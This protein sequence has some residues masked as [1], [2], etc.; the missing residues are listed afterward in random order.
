MH[1]KQNLLQIQNQ[2]AYLNSNNIMQD[3]ISKSIY[4]EDPSYVRNNPSDESFIQ[5]VINQA[6]NS[7][8]KQ[9]SSANISSRLHTS[10]HITSLNVSDRSAQDDVGNLNE[11]N[12]SYN[13]HG[14]MFEVYEDYD[15]FECTTA[16]AII[17]KDSE[18]REPVS[19][20]AC[21]NNNNIVQDNV[22]K[23]F[24]DKDSSYVSNTSEDGFVQPV[25]D[26][27]T[28]SVAKQT[29]SSANTSSLLYI[30][31]S[32][33]GVQN[34]VGNLNEACLNNTKTVQ[35]NI[36]KNIHNEDTSYV[37]SNTSSDESFVQPVMDQATNSL[38]RETNSSANT[39]SGL[40]ISMSLNTSGKCARDDA[41]MFVTSAGAG[42]KKHFCMYCNMFQS[43]IAR[44]LE[45]VHA[46]ELEVQKFKHICQKEMQNE[47]RF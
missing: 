6:T 31:I 41:E 26:H 24:Y 15:L 23:N 7:V 27:A 45:R 2:N 33:R 34:D 5:A 29:N 11:D 30:N 4:D 40:D 9:N 16:A 8:V 35:D 28:N 21:L 38:A 19:T 32:D 25:I 1:E 3:N 12:F 39:S 20:K 42:N 13:W 22:S 18:I 37:P 14:N 10:P 46:N 17:S 36:S 47:K 43:K 44:H